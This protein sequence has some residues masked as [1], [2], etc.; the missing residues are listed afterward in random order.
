MKKNAIFTLIITLALLASNLLEA[1]Q[2][3]G[4]LAILIWENGQWAEQE[5]VIEDGI[6]STTV[7]EGA[8]FALVQK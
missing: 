8:L 7:A 5:V 3:A 2:N 4:N 6:I 1:D